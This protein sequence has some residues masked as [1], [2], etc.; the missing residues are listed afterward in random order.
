MNEEAKTVD[1]LCEIIEASS[2]LDDDKHLISELCTVGDDNL[3]K[4]VCIKRAAR[5]RRIKAPIVVLKKVAM[6]SKGQKPK[7]LVLLF[8]TFKSAKHVYSEAHLP[9][10]SD[11]TSI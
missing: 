7:K 5:V 4:S 9:S 8:P 6:S 2:F 11:M 10:D 3:P 1:L